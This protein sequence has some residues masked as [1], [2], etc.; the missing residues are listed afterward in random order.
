MKLWVDD[1]RKMPDNFDYHAKTANEAIMMLQ[2]HAFTEISL[3]HDL[4][5]PSAGTGYDVAK[6]IEKAA[7]FRFINPLKIHLHTDNPVGRQN[8]TLAITSA[9]RF[10]NVELK[11]VLL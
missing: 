2:T 6:W 11:E 1:L 8:M 9:C 7:Y 5:E 4:G 10:W 3:D